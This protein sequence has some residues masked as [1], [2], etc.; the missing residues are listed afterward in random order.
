MADI[1]GLSERTIQRDIASSN[2]SLNSEI[3]VTS[4]NSVFSFI[5]Y[6]NAACP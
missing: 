3:Q 1:P 4:F 6:S 5:A 2:I